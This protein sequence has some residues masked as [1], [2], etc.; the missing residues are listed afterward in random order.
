[1]S[2]LAGIY[3]NSVQLRTNALGMSLGKI[4]HAYQFHV[5]FEPEIQ[6]MKLKR[7]LVNRSRDIHRGWYIPHSTLYSLTPF[8]DPE[9][10]VSLLSP[11]SFLP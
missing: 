3:G 9:T 4:I 6:S 2:L 1:V 5:D 11:L 7:S 8:T 10:D